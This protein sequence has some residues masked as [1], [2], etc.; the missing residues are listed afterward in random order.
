M[1]NMKDLL[2][3]STAGRWLL[4]AFAFATVCPI[5]PDFQHQ[6]LA[7]E[8]KGDVVLDGTVCSAPSIQSTIFNSGQITGSVTKQQVED[9]AR[10]LDAG[11]LPAKIRPVKKEEH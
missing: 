5:G 6:T 9:L 1:K 7:V 4:I 8:P 2:P 10:V 3:T 11:S